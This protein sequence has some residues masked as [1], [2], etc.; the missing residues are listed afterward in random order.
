[1][2][3]TGIKYALDM[4]FGSRVYDPWWKRFWFRITKSKDWISE[5]EARLDQEAK[6]RGDALFREQF[7]IPLDKTFMGQLRS[8]G[9]GFHGPIQFY[10][11]KKISDEKA[12]K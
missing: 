6:A 12:D 10:G 3:E 5:R 2:S 7:S 8:G 1:M 9:K 11:N 4:Y